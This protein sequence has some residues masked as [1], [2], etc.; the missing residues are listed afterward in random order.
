[1]FFKRNVSLFEGNV[2]LLLFIVD[3]LLLKM[4]WLHE[5][6]QKMGHERSKFTGIPFTEIFNFL[7][8]LKVNFKE[9]LWNTTLYNLFMHLPLEQKLFIC[10]WHFWILHKFL[11]NKSIVLKTFLE[12]QKLIFRKIKIYVRRKITQGVIG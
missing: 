10:A 5:I 9:V 12:D 2:C 7:H 1:M 3:P 6:R 8:K 4:L 11:K